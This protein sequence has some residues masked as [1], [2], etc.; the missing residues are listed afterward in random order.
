MIGEIIPSSKVKNFFLAL[1]GIDLHS[2]VFIGRRTT[3]IDKFFPGLIEIHER[4]SI[5]PGCILV[6]AAVPEPSELK[7]TSRNVRIEK[8][9]IENDVWLGSGV[10][11]LPGVRIGKKSIVGAGSVVTKNVPENETWIGSPARKIKYNG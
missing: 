11:V 5:S 9:I 4:V 6:A 7:K 2:S 8:I 3:F 1:S 10:I